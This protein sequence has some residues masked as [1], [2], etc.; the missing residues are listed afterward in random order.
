VDR[1][2]LDRVYSCK[3]DDELLALAVERKSLEQE[4]QSVLWDELRRRKLPLSFLPHM[5]ASDRM[6]GE[7]PAWNLPAKC[8]G[9]AAVLARGQHSDHAFPCRRRREGKS[10]MVGREFMIP[11]QFQRLAA[12]WLS[13]V[14]DPRDFGSR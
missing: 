7:N 9:A 1:S 3:T 10:G 2:G 8:A 14:H 5:K 13:V 11:L 4:A 12:H 6:S